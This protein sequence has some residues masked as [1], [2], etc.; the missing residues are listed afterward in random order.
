MLLR[1]L[2]CKQQ[3]PT[4]VKLRGQIIYRKRNGEFTDL[5]GKLQVQL[6]IGTEVH[7]IQLTLFPRD[8]VDAHQQSCSC[9]PFCI[10][11]LWMLK[12]NIQAPKPPVVNLRWPSCT[13]KFTTTL[14]QIVFCLQC[15]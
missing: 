12:P 4:L 1:S 14:T 3:K 13:L 15:A 6:R 7:K 9:H 8:N 5:P 2:I 10:P 11:P